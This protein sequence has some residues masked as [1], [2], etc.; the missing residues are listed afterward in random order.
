MKKKKKNQKKRK[1]DG[2]GYKLEKRKGKKNLGA[3]FLKSF[4]FVFFISLVWFTVNL[5]Y[6]IPW[7]DY[8]HRENH[9]DMC[10]MGMNGEDWEYSQV[11]GGVVRSEWYLR[12]KISL[13]TLL[14]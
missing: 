14:D 6:L 11:Y 10:G 4:T 3:Y 13:N 2:T 8:N 1:R 5:F 12:E 7:S 9:H